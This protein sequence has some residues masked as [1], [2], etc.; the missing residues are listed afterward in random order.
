[1][2]NNEKDTRLAREVIVAFRNLGGTATR[3][4]IRRE[5]RDN[6]KVISEEEVDEEKRSRN[7]NLYSPFYWLPLHDHQIGRASCRERV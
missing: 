3:N 4:E 2:A 7:G 6:S 1:M 5:I